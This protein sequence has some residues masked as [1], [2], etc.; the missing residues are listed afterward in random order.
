MN[1]NIEYAGTR[2][3]KV[4]ASKVPKER[5]P[6]NYKVEEIDRVVACSAYGAIETVKERYGYALFDIFTELV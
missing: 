1:W 2:E 5:Y 4:F 3:Y 6:E